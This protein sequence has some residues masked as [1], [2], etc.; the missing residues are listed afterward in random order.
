MSEGFVKTIKVLALMTSSGI[1]VFCG[2]SMF[3][4]I[5]G[6]ALGGGIKSAS[7]IFDMRVIETI[8]IS[9]FLLSL[10]LYKLRDGKKLLIT[11]LL[12]FL[13][14]IIVYYVLSLIMTV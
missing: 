11:F 9:E 2:V 14:P 6:A 3:Y 7:D 1:V 8:F 5:G 10:I 4:V 12:V 13:M